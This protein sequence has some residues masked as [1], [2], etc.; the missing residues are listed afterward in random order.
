MGKVADSVKQDQTDSTYVSTDYAL[1]RE[2]TS[3]NMAA[4]RFEY[5]N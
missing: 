2:T 1:L 3:S 5:K 4:S